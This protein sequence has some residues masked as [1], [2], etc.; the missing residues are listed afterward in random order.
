[1]SNYK[2]NLTDDEFADCVSMYEKRMD[3]PWEPAFIKE[4]DVWV[5][6]FEDAKEYFQGGGTT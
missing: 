1:M 4:Q 2:R 6:A 5:Q 3:G